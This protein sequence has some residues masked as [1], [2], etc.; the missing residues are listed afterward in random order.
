[1]AVR[2]PDQ[3]RDT[4]AR[5]AGSQHPFEPYREQFERLD[6]ARGLG[7]N[8]LREQVDCPPGVY[9]SIPDGRTF[10]S[11]EEFW[12]ATKGAPK[13]GLAGGMAT[14]AVNVGGTH[15]REIDPEAPPNSDL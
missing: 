9:G 1:M 15:A 13:G 5:D 14:G 4:G 7:L 8:D 6:W 3:T 2:K 12:E 10:H 11:F